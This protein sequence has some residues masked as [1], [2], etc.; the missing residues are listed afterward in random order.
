MNSRLRRIEGLPPIESSFGLSVNEGLITAASFPWL[1]IGFDPGGYWPVESERFMHWLEGVQPDA[2]PPFTW[3]PEPNT[4]FGPAQL[5]YWEG[6]ELIHILTR[7][8]VDLLAGFLDEYEQFASTAGAGRLDELAA[9]FVGAE[10]GGVSV[11]VT[12]DGETT[13]ATA[14]AANAAGDPITPATPFRV[15]SITKTFIATIILQLV[16]EGRVHLDNPLSTYLPDTPV[17]ADVTIR[18]L[19]SH[20]SGIPDYTLSDDFLTDAPAD[21]SRWFTA[22]EIVGYVEAMGPNGPD[23]GGYSNT[24]YI[25]LGQLVERLDGTDPATSLATRIT[26]PLGLTDTRLATENDLGIDGLAGGWTTGWLDGIPLAGDPDTPYNSIISSGRFSGGLISS[27]G[28]LA[29]FLT[30]LFAGDLISPEALDEMTTIGESG[31]G[32]GLFPVELDSG[33]W[34]LGHNGF[35]GGYRSL[36]AINPINGDVVV[37]LTNNDTLAPEDMLW[38]VALSS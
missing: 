9:S 35:M 34:G 11:L 31:N 28:D 19:L 36:M 22:D 17:G 25:L 12:R 29:T 7:D 26:G 21:P 30:A 4:P 38:D 2:H 18:S 5:F 15:A 20:Q 27:T 37:V 13:T 10:E 33:R 16:D 6:Q 23:Q 32:L 8:T 24:N 3:P 14:G 1:S